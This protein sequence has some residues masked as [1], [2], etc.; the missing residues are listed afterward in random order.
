ML[1]R[2]IVYDKDSKQEKYFE[3]PV[4]GVGKFIV[5]CSIWDISIICFCGALNFPLL[6]IPHSKF[7][8]ATVSKYYFLFCTLSYITLE[9]IL[10]KKILQIKK[11][12]IHFNLG[13]LM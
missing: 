11:I 7:K 4:S 1:G 6:G 5:I 13:A 8:K 12:C 9:L 3:I 10:Y 2:V